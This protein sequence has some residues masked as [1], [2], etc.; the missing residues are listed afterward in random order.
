MSSDFKTWD[1]E[2]A[3]PVGSIKRITE[4]WEESGF[5]YNH[6]RC[7]SCGREI[8]YEYSVMIRR[9]LTHVACIDGHLREIGYNIEF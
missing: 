3:D 2:D 8:G 9:G 1:S 5:I 6:Q 4:R 7:V